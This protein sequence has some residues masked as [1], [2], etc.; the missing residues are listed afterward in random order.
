MLSIHLHDDGRVQITEKNQGKPSKTKY[1]ALEEVVVAFRDQAIA[2]PLMPLGTVQYWQGY[3]HESLTV[4][5]EPHQRTM[6]LE[7]ENYNLPVPGLLFG[8]RAQKHN[9]G[10]VF[11]ESSVFAVKGQFIGEKT[12]L[13]QFP[14]GNVFDDNKICWGEVQTEFKNIFQIASLIDVFLSSNFNFD[15]DGFYTEIDNRKK[16]EEE[17]GLEMFWKSMKKETRFP[18]HRLI[19]ECKYGEIEKHAQ[20]LIN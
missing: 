14:Y 20:F 9:G 16:D 19:E 6:T 11:S 5:R 10:L 13:C 15:L 1:V 8:F 17:E 2:S 12:Q 18:E 7:D 4:Y 3:Q